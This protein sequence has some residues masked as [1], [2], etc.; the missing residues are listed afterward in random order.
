MECIM[1]TNNLIKKWKIQTS[2]DKISLED[3][4]GAFLGNLRKIV[5]KYDPDFSKISKRIRIIVDGQGYITCVT[6]LL[7]DSTVR[8]RGEINCL[9]NIISE[10]TTTDYLHCVPSKN[11][12]EISFE[13]IEQITF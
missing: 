12:M 9:S 3:I 10:L 4:R 1:L 13:E 11:V 5:V 7:Y 8:Y 2:L 6:L